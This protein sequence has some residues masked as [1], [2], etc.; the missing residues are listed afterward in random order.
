MTRVSPLRGTLGEEMF[1][2]VCDRVGAQSLPEDLSGGSFRAV[3]HRT[4]DGYADQVD[5]SQLPPLASGLT[6]LQGNVVPLA[7]Q[8]ADRAHAIARVETLARHRA[9]LI[10]AL[11][12][13]IPDITIPVVDRGAADPRQSCA[14][15]GQARLHDALTE[16][17][18]R[19]GPLYDDG[20]LPAQTEAVAQIVGAFLNDAQAQQAWSHF[21]A[22][23][24]YRQL[25]LALGAARAAIA[26]PAMRSMSDATLRLV[27]P[28][29]DPYAAAPP[30]DADGHRVPVPGAAYAQLQKLLQAA[31]AEL[32]N[33]TADP[34]VTALFPA[35]SPARDPQT[36]VTLLARPRTTL[37]LLQ[38]VLR[39]SDPV[40]GTPG[41]PSNYLVQ[42]D[43]RGYAQVHLVS[44]KVP[45]PFVDADGDGLADVD[46][47]GRFV[48][49]NGA[50][51]PPPFAL[52]TADGA[53]L[54]V[55]DVAPRD[56]FLRALSAPGGALVY[57]YFDA[58]HAP[59]ASILRHVHALVDPNPAD[60]H[61]TLMDLLA[62]AAVI[63]G[64]RDGA[65]KTTRAYADGESV[66]YDA[67]HTEQSPV[68]DLVYGLNQTLAD[69]SA[70]ETLAFASA[71]VSDH[72]DDVARVA[73][74]ALW[75]KDRANAD[76]TAHIPPTSTLWD[77]LIDM[78]I[79]VEKEPGL[80]AD[81]LRAFAD[82]ATPGL[83][84]A[85][86]N[87]M[88]TSDR[89]SYDRQN[90]NGAPYNF[91]T[92]DGSAP[93]TPVDRS[94]PDT[95]AN[96]SL[97]QRFIQITSDAWGVA[98]CNK[99]GAVVHANILLG[100]LTIPKD[101]CGST[102]GGDQGVL[103]DP[104]SMCKSCSGARPFHECE[105]F[106]VDNLGKF[107]VDSMV[108]KANLYF[109]PSL[110]RNGLCIG[111]T[112]LGASTVATIEASGIGT[113]AGN[114]PSN[115]GAVGF[116]DDSTATTFRPKPAW[117]NRQTFFDQLG[118]SP[119][120]GGKN[121]AVNHFLTDLQGPYMGTSICPERVIADP[122][123]GD[124]QCGGNDAASVASDGMVHGLRSCADGNWLQQRDQDA[125]F[126]SEEDDL[127]TSVTPLVTAFAS[128]G[129]EDLFLEMMRI[130]ERH[131]QSAA[132]TASE[133]VTGIDANGKPI[134]C[135]RDGLDTYE[136]LAAQILSSDVLSAVSNLLRVA[137]GLQ[138][139]TCN[140]PV[141]PRTHVCP[142]GSVVTK[143]GIDVLVDS[144]VALMDPDRAKSQHLTDRAGNVTS[145]RNDGTTNPQVT[146]LYLITQ[147]MDGIDDAFAAYAQAHPQDAQRQAQWRRA[148]SQLAD[149]VLSTNHPNTP[150]QSFNEPGL[151]K[152]LPLVIDALRA[153]LL[154][155]CTPAPGAPP[156][157][158]GS[159][160]DWARHGLTRNMAD[161]LGGPLFATSTDLQDAIRADTAARTTTEAFLQYLT[162]PAS[163]NAAVGSLLT[164]ANDLIQVGMDD[165]DL[166]PLYHVLA[167][168]TTSWTDDHGR[169]RPSVIDATTAMLSRSAGR[170]YDAAGN[171]ICA[172][173]LDPDDVLDVVLAHA[174]TPM[175]LASGGDGETPLEVILDAIADV[176]RAAPGAGGKLAPTDYA[177]IG[178]ELSSFLTDDQRGLEQLYA[179]IRQGTAG[180]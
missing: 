139:P 4:G 45:A 74:D 154:A 69:P 6:D 50:A 63:M 98:T 70:D 160:C 79:E 66:T 58:S 134:A 46:A 48:T 3:C 53:L 19:F 170:A 61:E 76:T 150:S 83:G 166:V 179:I 162:D 132:G 109:R 34:P 136:P 73:G 67:F 146:P 151:A 104:D 161:T 7:Q 42:R 125:T 16:L 180:Q 149:E 21:D 118:D 102:S 65:P 71:L 59:L 176:N 155:R 110:I 35:G 22:R 88:T 44:G 90:L 137:G 89:I 168:A 159:V 147:A 37:E 78:S 12:S 25:A 97:M 148:R 56:T 17:L 9:D 113:D 120:P 11:D 41:A 62:G 112:C 105:V 152:L 52:G 94:K 40:F 8:Q 95:G 140:G 143:T 28:D 121:Y 36:G 130:L 141:D 82:P 142:A 15:A 47:L 14:P 144:T 153:Q 107:F 103:C 126:V 165:T 57:D 164:T 175:K 10:M 158:A 173:E 177:S 119:A 133:C 169:Q 93:R 60:Q 24:G 55:P 138:V 145:R 30:L 100:G 26:Y 27:S 33:T 91:T 131:W 92:Q 127:V 13:A 129:R 108:K 87:F 68:L 39:T 128:H 101:V 178:A 43:T 38:S 117:L 23:A 84:K 32:L 122:C 111:T 167:A 5:A 156:A 115:P 123:N 81:V 124:A 163:P 80:L 49:A 86:G 31:H 20:T 174:V 157:G 171:E 1:G 77:E 114:G 96:R 29:S 18:A 54:P 116:W 72:S 85:L 75:A 106:K 64:A 172:N 135:T 2:V 99:E 51:A